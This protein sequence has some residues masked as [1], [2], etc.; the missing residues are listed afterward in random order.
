MD[1]TFWA[2]EYFKIAGMGVVKAPNIPAMATPYGRQGLNAAMTTPLT[3]PKRKTVN[4]LPQPTQ[5][6]PR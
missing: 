4:P 3:L 1:T 5:N 2:T 6:P